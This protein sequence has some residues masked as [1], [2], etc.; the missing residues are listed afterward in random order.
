MRTSIPIS[1]PEIASPQAEPESNLLAR[2]PFEIGLRAFGKSWGMKTEILVSLKTGA[3]T[4]YRIAKDYE[5]SHQY[6]ARLAKR[7]RQ[8]RNAGVD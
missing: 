1:P 4:L 2:L 5:V 8:I 7:V 6:V 3:P